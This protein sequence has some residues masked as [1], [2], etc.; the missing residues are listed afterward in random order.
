MEQVFEKEPFYI[1]LPEIEEK[2][3]KVEEKPKEIKKKLKFRKHAKQH[4][5]RIDINKIRNKMNASRY[6]A[7]LYNR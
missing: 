1:V 2:A 3:E 7:T 4:Q 6:R 5:E